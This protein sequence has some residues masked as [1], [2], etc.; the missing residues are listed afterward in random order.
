M[1]NIPTAPTVEKMYPLLAAEL[2]Q[3]DGS[4]F[5]LTEIR[6]LERR[7][8][9][10]RDHRANI[11]KKYRR[12]INAVDCIDTVLAASSLGMGAVG[13]GLLSTIIA[14]PIVVALEAAAVACGFAGIAGKY[15]SRWL[16]VKA[17]KHDEIR[18]LALSKLNSITDV[19]S[20]ALRDGRISPEEFKLV[21]DEMDKYGLMKAKIREKTRKA[22]Q[23]TEAGVFWVRS[24]AL[25]ATFL[26]ESTAAVPGSRN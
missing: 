20:N 12:A 18:V 4:S 22:A 15:I 26:Y 1:P 7:L 16:L 21:L 2:Q 19:I 23:S 14:A 6:N 13:V 10:E 8:E 11:Y 9:Q 24:T 3:D 17:K 25:W 5:R